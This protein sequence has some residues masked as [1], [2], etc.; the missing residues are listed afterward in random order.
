MKNKIDRTFELPLVSVVVA[1]Y[2]SS[3]TIVETLE[4]I[5]RQTY[6]NVELIVTDDCSMDDTVSIVEEW[7]AINRTRFVNVKNVFSNVN[8]GVACNANRGVK[9]SKGVFVKSIA[10]DD[11][12]VDE[13]IEKYVSFMLSTENV[14]CVSDVE[15]F[16]VNHAIPDAKITSYKRCFELC[17]ENREA[18]LRRLAYEY[19]LLSPGYFYSRELFDKIGGYDERFPMSEEVPFA[20]RVLKAG[21]DI[22]PFDE[23][24]VRYRYSGVSLSQ[25]YGKKL[26]NRRW[27]LDN[28]KIYYRIQ[29]PELLKSFRFLSAYSKM[30]QYEQTNL[31]YFN[32]ILPRIGE[33]FLCMLNP[34]TYYSLILKF[35]KNNETKIM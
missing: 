33:K 32:G 17:K 2:N 21:Y 12:L 25:H 9:A 7:V 29:M 1:T 34:Y 3:A 30:I 10:G 6:Q 4:S 11:C 20:M 5:K 15:L 23:K 24:L 35:R 28:R 19:V 16:S 8:T 22:I 31:Q 14:I 18:K 26:G 27:F 13:A